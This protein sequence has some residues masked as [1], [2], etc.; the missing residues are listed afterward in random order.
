MV[1]WEEKHKLGNLQI[2]D[3]RDVQLFSLSGL[4][5]RTICFH[6]IERKK[7]VRTSIQKKVLPEIQRSV[8]QCLDQNC[9]FSM[10]A[11]LHFSLN[12][13]VNIFMC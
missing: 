7:T 11:S 12:R 10:F 13:T 2:P 6:R 3:L 8:V 1:V 9:V 5:K 4:F